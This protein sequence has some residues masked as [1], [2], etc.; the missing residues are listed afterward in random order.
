MFGPVSC[1]FGGMARTAEQ[2]AIPASRSETG[3]S[4]RT[5]ALAGVNG[6]ADPASALPVVRFR[7]TPPDSILSAA[8]Q[9]AQR[10]ARASS[11]APSCAIHAPWAIRMRRGAQAS[12]RSTA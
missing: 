5:A 8:A 4:N 6:M 2:D 10:K 3:L 9:R 12:I 1:L 11:A 7:H